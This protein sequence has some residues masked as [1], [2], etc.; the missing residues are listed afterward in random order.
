MS[1][2]RS[3]LGHPSGRI[4]IEDG[5]PLEAAGFTLCGLS[6]PDSLPR[7]ASNDVDKGRICKRCRAAEK[8]GKS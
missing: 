4:H 7:L 2:G 1:E 5:S 3:Y 6:L 8:R